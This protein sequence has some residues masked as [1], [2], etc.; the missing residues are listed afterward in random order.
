MITFYVIMNSLLKNIKIERKFNYSIYFYY[1]KTMGKNNDGYRIGAVVGA[2]QFY[3]KY[4][5][6]WCKVRNGNIVQMKKDGDKFKGVR[7]L[8]F[9]DI[10]FNEKPGKKAIIKTQT[11]KERN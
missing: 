2:I 1:Y 5:K 6:K 3:H 11:L 9:D 10:N 8:H 4:E 7:E